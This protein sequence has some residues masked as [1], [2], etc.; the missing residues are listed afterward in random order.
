MN[1]YFLKY[2]VRHG[3][4]LGFRINA[5]HPMS[6]ANYIDKYLLKNGVRG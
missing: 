3:I 5:A 1:N 4:A 2:A 6:T